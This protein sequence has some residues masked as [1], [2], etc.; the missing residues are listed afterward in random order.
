MLSGGGSFGADVAV[1]GTAMPLR[2]GRVA[3]EQLSCGLSGASQIAQAK[4]IGLMR[5][6]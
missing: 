2:E 4:R 3:Q 6:L 5:K 1:A